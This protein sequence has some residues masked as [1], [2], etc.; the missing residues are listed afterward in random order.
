MLALIK[1]NIRYSPYNNNKLIEYQTPPVGQL[2][3]HVRSSSGSIEVLVSIILTISI[4]AEENIWAYE[5]TGEWK[6]LHNEELNDF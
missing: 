1:R 6:K 4:S 3:Q 5:V 2:P